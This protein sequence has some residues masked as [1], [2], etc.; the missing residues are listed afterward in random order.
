MNMDKCLSSCNQMPED[1]E[2]HHQD[3]DEDIDQQDL[4]VPSMAKIIKKN[5]VPYIVIE[6]NGRGQ[7]IEMEA[8]EYY[9]TLKKLIEEHHPGSLV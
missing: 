4:D 2:R 1:D 3:L 8:F 9:R 7:R 5:G 6:N